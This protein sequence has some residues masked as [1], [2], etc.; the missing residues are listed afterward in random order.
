[1]GHT[2]DTKRHDNN[3]ARAGVRRSFLVEVISKQK[4]NVKK[5]YKTILGKEKSSKQKERTK[6]CRLEQ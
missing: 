2:T 3:M 5:V 1:M 6:D 4:L